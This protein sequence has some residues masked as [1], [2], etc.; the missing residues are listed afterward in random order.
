MRSFP[1]KIN[2]IMKSPLI[3]NVD[4]IYTVTYQH[5]EFKKCSGCSKFLNCQRVEWM[6]SKDGY[7]MTTWFC[8]E[9]H[10]LNIV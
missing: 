4:D 3:L 7:L 5:H 9:C 10:K 8:I 2:N 1:F 6:S